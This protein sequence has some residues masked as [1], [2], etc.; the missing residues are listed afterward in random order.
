MRI[1]F[2]VGSGISLSAGMPS[3]EMISAKVRSGDGVV[4]ISD[5]TFRLVN[6]D[7]GNYERAR[8]RATPTIEFTN[9]LWELANCYSSVV[10]KRSGVNYEEIANL[11]AQLADATDG[12][13][14]N[15]ATFPLLQRL[16]AGDDYVELHGRC[17]SAEEF[18]RDVVWGML[19]RPVGDT[20][21][22][23]CI[24][25]AC[26]DLEEV[27]I[28]DLNHDRVLEQTLRRAGLKVADGF[29]VGHGQVGVWASLFDAPIRHLKLHGSISWFSR[30]LEGEEWRGNSLTKSMGVGE[31]DHECGPNGELLQVTTESRPVILT[32][33]FAKP[34]SYD[35]GAFAE[36]HY[37]FHS[38]LRDG[39]LLIVTGYGF[40]DKAINTRLINWMLEA[41]N[42]SMLVIHGAPANLEEGARPAIQRFWGEWV[43]L[44]RL[45]I[46]DSWIEESSWPEVRSELLSMLPSTNRT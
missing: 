12:E 30:V 42:R 23:A 26:A 8:A 5:Q 6:S 32:G 17:R 7:F 41:R 13:Y 43:D 24:V 44:G 21:G 38:Y 31:A 28:F 2:L 36:L 34:L 16:V 20:K 11:A 10:L 35:G 4:R 40:Q 45:R 1:A 39:D 3:V 9:D 15:P 37:R 22:L 25:E 33:T 18:V 14:E 19:D 29:R 46:I 27:D